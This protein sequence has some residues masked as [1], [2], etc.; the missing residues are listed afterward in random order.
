MENQY[1]IAVKNKYELFLDED[2]DPLEILR[3]SEEQAKKKKD[4]KTKKDVKNEKTK[5]SKIKAAKNKAPVIE[6]KKVATLDQNANKK[7]ADKSR[8]GSAKPKLDRQESD[9]KPLTEGNRDVP[10]RRER[11][12]RGEKSERPQTSEFRDRDAGEGRGR[13]RGGRGRGRGRGRGTAVQ[14]GGFDRFGKREFERHSGSDKTGVKPVE[15]REGGGAHNWGTVKDDIDDQLNDTNNVSTDETPD[16]SATGEE[17]ENK[18]PKEKVEGEESEEIAEDE[19]VHEMT[20]EEWRAQQG[21]ERK[22]PDFKIRKAGEGVDGDQWKRTYALEPRKKVDSEDEEEEDEEEEED[23]G[24]RNK[25]LNI[26]ITFYDNPRR[27]RRR[28]RG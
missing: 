21:A 13:G 28:G 3:A 17:V 24:S 4:D 27:G 12:E 8:P 10:P 20:L 1:G 9:K 26:E 22:R 11:F 18:D 16:W 2:D 5:S 7:D 23:D 19:G 15:K 25:R 14:P 6:P